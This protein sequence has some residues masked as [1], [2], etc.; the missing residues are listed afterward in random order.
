[1]KL[2]FSI[3]VLALACSIAGCG[4][5]QSEL[6]G[7][8]ESQAG[9]D[10]AKAEQGIVTL[11][12][13]Q[14]DA[15]GI[16]TAMIGQK[17]LTSV[18]KASGQLAVPPQNKAEVNVLY[19]GLVKS[20][21]VLEGQSVSKGQTLA[22]LE[23]ADFIRL[24]QDYLAAKRGFTYVAQE[25]ERQQALKAADA[26][27]GKSYQLS[28][29]NYR[30]EQARLSGMEQQLRQAG[31]NPATVAGGKVLREIGIAAPIS[32]TI[33]HVS[34]NTGAYAQPGTPLM[35]IVD[36]S[37]IHADLTVYEKDLFKV[38]D[39]QKVRFL[40]T[41]QNNQE[42]LGEIYGINKSFEGD[43]KGI[44]VHADI[45]SNKYGLIPGMYVTALIDVG[46][47]LSPAVPTEAIVRSEG[48]DYIFVQTAASDGNREFRKVE[49]AA[50]VAEIGYTQITPVDE[51]P[52]DA[53]I[54][55]RGAFYVLSKAEAGAGED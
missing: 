52:A 19:G 3:A 50:G 24:Q 16:E 4:G 15:V 9:R 14:M 44:T 49:V 5:K 29:A 36:N 21:R 51:L 40:L 23:N 17:N 53:V 25:Y 45:R 46:E 10:T 43:T 22:T 27:T 54:I 1:M 28:E 30:A 8:V 18:V 42:I 26:G 2:K 41:N 13:K 7:K 32:G 48:R 39:G 37:H 12:R 11:S 47:Q 6:V 33:G 20:I 35:D 55:T 31:I 38:R 34:V